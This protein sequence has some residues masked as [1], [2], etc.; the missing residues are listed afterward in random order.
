MQRH[1]HRITDNSNSQSPC[2]YYCHLI[3]IICPFNNCCYPH[4][5]FAVCKIK[6][7]PTTGHEGPE[8]YEMYNCTDCLTS[9]PDRGGSFQPRSHRRRHGRQT[10]TTYNKPVRNMQVCGW[11]K[12][13]VK[14]GAKNHDQHQYHLQYL[15]CFV[16]TACHYAA[17]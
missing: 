17:S 12:R 7:H 6:I 1:N 8:G 2:K 14:R 9:S 10:F 13:S 5:R 11:A 3:L 15:Y 16:V 4:K